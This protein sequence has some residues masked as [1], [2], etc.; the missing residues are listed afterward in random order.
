MT[1]SVLTPARAIH[2]KP[3]GS[4]DRKHRR[5][6]FWCAQSAHLSS[7]PLKRRCMLHSATYTHAHKN[8]KI[9]CERYSKAPPLVTSV[10]VGT[11]DGVSKRSKRTKRLELSADGPGHTVS[12]RRI[13]RYLSV[14]QIRSQCV[15]TRYARRSRARKGR[16][17]NNGPCASLRNRCGL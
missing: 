1:Y 6:G 14:A 4:C 16:K 10:V 7:V 15:F 11:Q 2:I 13:V 3:L 5:E 9:L 17:R 8:F 12:M